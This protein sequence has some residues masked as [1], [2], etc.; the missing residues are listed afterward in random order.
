[1]K[2]AA[3]ILSFATMSLPAMAQEQMETESTFTK[4]SGGAIYDY[5]VGIDGA[6]VNEL[7]DLTHLVCSRGSDTLR[8]MLPLGEADDATA[9]TLDGTPSTLKKT[10]KSWQLTFMAYGKPVTK[11]I[12]FKPVNDK[13]SLHKQQLIFTVSTKEP[14]WKAMRD[15]RGNKAMA[16]IGTGG[17]PVEIFDDAKLTKFFAACRIKG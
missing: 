6:A 14:L 7:F 8:V 5:K 2:I 10:A 12:E 3:I 11:T 9:F 1:M 17:T 13:A 16:L 4:I 15:K